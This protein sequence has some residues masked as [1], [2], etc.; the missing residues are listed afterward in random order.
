MLNPTAIRV[1]SSYLNWNA[2]TLAKKAHISPGHISNIL[3][4]R[5]QMTPDV[6]ERIVEVFQQEGITDEDIFRLTVLLHEIGK[7]GK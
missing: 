5:Q 1:L 7:G 2:S 3:K 6:A 4:G